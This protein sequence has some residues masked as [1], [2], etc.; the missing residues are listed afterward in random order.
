LRDE[1]AGALAEAERLAA[2]KDAAQLPLFGIPVAVEGTIST[3]RGLPT[4]SACPAFGL[5]AP[6]RDATLGGAAARG[7]APS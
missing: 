5:Y 3:S 6:A 2:R 4:T 1:K 7:P